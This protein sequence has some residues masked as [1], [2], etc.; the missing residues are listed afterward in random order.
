VQATGLAP[1]VR[2]ATGYAWAEGPVLNYLDE[3]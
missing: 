3:P 1:A 2:A